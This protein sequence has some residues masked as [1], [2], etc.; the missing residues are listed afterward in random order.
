MTRP[1]RKAHLRI[2]M[3]LAVLLPILFA[4]AL[5]VRHSTTP[6]NPSVHWEQLR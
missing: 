4:R 6:A 3:A 2:W 1:L 5:M